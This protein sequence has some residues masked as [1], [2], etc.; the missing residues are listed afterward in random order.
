M[1]NP[2][3]AIIDDSEIALETAKEALEQ[4][5]FRTL[6]Y[7][8]S[9]GVQSFLLRNQPNILIIDIEM[10]S[11]KGDVLCRMIKKNQDLKDILIILHSGL[12]EADLEKMAAESGADG[13]VKKSS[14][15]SI[16]A[17]K[18]N[19]LWKTKSSS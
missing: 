19:R 12:P 17:E 11:L 18:I 5:C 15:F 6:T 14:D 16:L 1:T 13:F 8:K 4:F 7:A 2:V 9:L 10:P 3:V